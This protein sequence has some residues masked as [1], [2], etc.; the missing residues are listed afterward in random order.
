MQIARFLVRGSFATSRRY[1]AAALGL[2]FFAAFSSFGVQVRG[3]IGAHG[4]VPARS[5]LE[6]VQN[7]LGASAYFRVPTLAWLGSSDGALMAICVAGALLGLVL[8]AG[9]CPGACALG[10]WVLYLSLCSVG[11]PFLN[12][13]WDALLL[14]TGLLAVLMLPWRWRPDWSLESPRQRMGRWLMW[15]LLFRLMFESGVVK[16][17]WGDATW[18]EL[19]ALDFHFFT[20][21]L[22]LWTAWYVHHLPPWI[23]RALT[24][25]MF[26][27]EMLVPFLIV[28][29]RRWRHAAALALIGLQVFILATGNYAFFNWL[30][31]ALCLPLLDDGFWPERW[32]VRPES[33]AGSAPLPRP[34]AWIAAA[35]I[36]LSVVAATLPSLIGSFRVSIPDPFGALLGATRSFNGYGLFRVMTTE[37]PEIVVEGSRD[38]QIWKAYE[39]RW[40]PNGPRDRP[41]LVAPHQPRLDWQM[42]FAAL[43][44]VRHNPWFLNFLVRLLEGSP[45]VLDLLANNPFPD[46]PPRYVRAVLYDYQFTAWSD[47]TAAWW[48]PEKKGLYCPPIS[49][50]T[51]E[52][53]PR[54]N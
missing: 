47:D 39:F 6:A 30:T 14:E 11:E 41:L 17:T 44:D 12:F 43:G 36:G 54:E 16:L 19:R 10:C 32:R 9:V 2:I 50:R 26:V 24:F 31:I 35:A 22:P 48:R 29:P 28:S 8:A 45:E 21:P 37:R 52:E 7:S 34:V 23:L 20:Q 46:Q 53:K 49:L 15:W 27:I 38:G 33:S 25:L 18:R 4:I 5:F 1:F 42:W 3:L 51:R 40:K 13:Q